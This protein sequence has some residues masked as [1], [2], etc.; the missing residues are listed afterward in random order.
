MTHRRWGLLSMTIA[1]WAALAP[2]AG[3]TGAPR[4]QT[5]AA[6][7][8]AW[9]LVHDRPIG[10]K[11][12]DFAFP[13]PKDGW[14]VSAPGDILH[15]GDGGV[16]WAVQAQGKG[17]L[18]SI[19]FLDDKRGFAGTLTGILHGTTDGGVTWTDITSTLPRPPKGFC[20]ITHVGERVHLVGK[21]T[22]EAADYYYSPDGGRTWRVSDLSN[23]AQ[24][25]VDVSFL[26]ESVGLIGGMAP[27]A[28]RGV[29]PA[30]ILKTTDGGRNWRPVFTHDGGRGFAWK[31]WPI[32]ATLIYAAL[33]SQDGIYRTAKSTDAG[34][35]WEVQTVATGRPQGPAVQGIGFLD[36]RTGWVG[37]FFQGMYA[38]TDGGRTW[39][40]VP[41]A[42][43]TINRFEK[44]GATLFT[45]GTRGILR[46]DGRIGRE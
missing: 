25:L 34:D 19:D 5:T 14:L 1:G 31:L 27:S 45:A 28:S 13:T 20:G 12:E 44:V 24:G 26:N 42:D 3:W 43:R 46:Y 36:E 8:A 33:Q 7:T 29:G 10:G 41:L 38:T 11:Y 37:G 18:R 39:A 40:A 21:Y 17:R 15:T 22:A 9:T 16:T 35:T 6:D 30:I 32:S 2:A 23:V 4:A